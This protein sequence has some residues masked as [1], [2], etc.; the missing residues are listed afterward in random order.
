MK[1]VISAFAGLIMALI[2]PCAVVAVDN[3]VVSRDRSDDSSHVCL[4]S[5]RVSVHTLQKRLPSDSAA[6]HTFLWDNFITGP[7][8]K[9]FTCPV[10]G[11]RKQSQSFARVLVR[12][13][14]GDSLDGA[15]LEK[16]LASVLA[17]SERNAYLPISATKAMYRKAPAWIILVKWEWADSSPREVLAHSRVFVLNAKDAHTVAFAT[18]D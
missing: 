1:K 17:D 15:S 10:L 4:D 8:E 3:P 18:C 16:C 5:S 11:W 7:E 2:L 14:L 13:A 9:L 12:K 6:M